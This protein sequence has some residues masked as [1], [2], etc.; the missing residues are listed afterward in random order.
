MK[1]K[2]IV[3]S[4]DTHAQAKAKAKEKGMTLGGYITIL[5]REDIKRD[6]NDK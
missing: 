3:V 4:E 5:V 2:H 1:D 6:K